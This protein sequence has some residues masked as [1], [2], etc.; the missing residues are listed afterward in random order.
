M[1]DLLNTE[2]K[3]KFHPTVFFFLYFLRLRVMRKS[4]ASSQRRKGKLAWYR[5]N[6]TNCKHTYVYFAAAA[7]AA[8][9]TWTSWDSFSCLHTFLWLG[10]SAT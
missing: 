1:H 2:E 8:A 5:S 7:V 10:Q 9:A 4:V 3:R 6:E